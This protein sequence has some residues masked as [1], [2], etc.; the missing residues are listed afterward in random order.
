VNAA[1]THETFHQES[2]MRYQIRPF[3]PDLNSDR[4]SSLPSEGPKHPYQ[5]L[6]PILE[7]WASIL[8]NSFTH[9]FS[10]TM[11]GLAADCLIGSHGRP[12]DPARVVV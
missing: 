5:H 7:R 9:D 6:R 11:P 8:A 1:E 12:K 4:A 10:S 2:G 3:R